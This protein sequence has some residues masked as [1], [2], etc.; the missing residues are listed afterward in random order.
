[1][2]ILTSV[3][4]SALWREDVECH[5]ARRHPRRRRQRHRQTTSIAKLAHLYTS[6]GESVV[7]AAGDTF[8]AAPSTSSRVVG[9]RGAQ[10]VAQRGLDPG[11]VA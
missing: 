3:P 8:R 6:A 7:V 2:A 11:A 4:F 10:I 1:M 5:H 9:A